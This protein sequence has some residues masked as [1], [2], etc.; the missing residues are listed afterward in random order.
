ME[1]ESRRRAARGCGGG[2]G[3]G[4]RGMGGH[5][6]G[7]RGLVFNRERVSVLQDEKV[8]ETVTVTAAQLRECT[9]CHSTGHLKNGQDG[10]CHATRILPQIK[11]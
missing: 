7:G 6:R 4:G 10:K 9:S 8:L 1:T 3:A 5:G 2:R 11:N